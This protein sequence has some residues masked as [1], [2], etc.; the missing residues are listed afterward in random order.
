[1]AERVEVRQGNVVTEFTYGDYK[2][3]N[4]ELNKIEA[5]YA[6]TLVEKR[7]GATDARPQDGRD[8]DR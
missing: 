5:F 7:N 1:M 2:D 6:G 3:W 4:N 8:R